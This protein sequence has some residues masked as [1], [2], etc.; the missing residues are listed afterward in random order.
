MH[1]RRCARRARCVNALRQGNRDVPAKPP[2][3]FC[4]PVCFVS[5]LPLQE[6]GGC[7]F[8]PGGD[9]AFSAE[10]VLGEL[11]GCRAQRSC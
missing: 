1:A 9:A 6:A 8:L 11:C 3:D 5:L 10:V 2:L 7:C 4:C